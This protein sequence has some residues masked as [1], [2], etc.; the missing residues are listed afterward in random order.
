MVRGIRVIRV[1]NRAIR[2]IMV[3]NRAIRVIRVIMCCR[4][5]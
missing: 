1:D 4:V 3:D 2:V 5:C